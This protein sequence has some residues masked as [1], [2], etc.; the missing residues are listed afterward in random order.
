MPDF[1]HAAAILQK[2]GVRIP[3]GFRPIAVGFQHIVAS[4]VIHGYARSFIA[5]ADFHILPLYLQGHFMV[6]FGASL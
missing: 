3:G 2:N 6:F 1:E 5:K 4:R